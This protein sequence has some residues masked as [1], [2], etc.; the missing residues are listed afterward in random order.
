MADKCPQPVNIFAVHVSTHGTFETCRRAV[1]VFV[2]E[3][4]RRTVPEA[5]ANRDFNAAF[6]PASLKSGASHP[7]GRQSA[8]PRLA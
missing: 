7:A 1:T 5:A 4:N 8:Q 6:M 3:G 2:Y